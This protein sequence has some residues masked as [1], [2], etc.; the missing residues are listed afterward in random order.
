MYYLLSTSSLHYVYLHVCE[1]LSFQ[2]QQAHHS[3]R[4]LVHLLRQQ[5]SKVQLVAKYVLD[6]TTNCKLLY[7]YVIFIGIHYQVLVWTA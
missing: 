2:Q 5:V 4:D 1:I 7:I 3:H 6:L